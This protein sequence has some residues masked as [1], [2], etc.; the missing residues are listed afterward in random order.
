MLNNKIEEIKWCDEKDMKK[1]KKIR[2]D[3]KDEISFKKCI[4]DELGFSFFKTGNFEPKYNLYKLDQTTLELRLEIPGN[5]TCK[6]ST[7]V[8]KENTVIKI[9]GEKTEDKLPIDENDKIY[10]R[11]EF[12]NFEVLIPLLTEKY[13]ILGNKPKDNPEHKDELWI[14]NFELENE[15]IEDAEMSEVNDN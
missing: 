2:L 1:R 12:N 6:A 5:A 14:F 9:K 11:R 7:K 13:Q 15:Q 3:L 10:N 4:I 8:I